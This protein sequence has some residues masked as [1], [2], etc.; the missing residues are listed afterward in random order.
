MGEA[1]GLDPDQDEEGR[2][3][4]QRPSIATLAGLV[5]AGA[6]AAPGLA[7]AQQLE[8]PRPSP[9]ARVMRQIGLTEITVDYSSPAVRKRRIWGALV[10]YDKPWRTGANAS[11]RVTFTKDVSVGGKTVPAG[12]YALLTIPG[13]KTWTVMLNRNTELAGNMDRYRPEEDVVRVTAVPR[14]IP[15]QE[16]L[17]FA[18]SGVTEDACVLDMDWEKLRISLPIKTFTAQ[19]ARQNIDRTLGGLWR[20]YANAA[21]Y[22]KD[23]KDYDAALKYIDQSLA[24]KEDWFNLWTKAEILAA[25]GER[26]QALALAQKAD[27]LGSKNPQG[28]I[29]AADVK[30]AL[31]EWKR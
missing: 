16:W 10:P 30:K 21:R 24:M 17:S 28:F 4:M 15:H 3:L 18:F 29:Y 11:T 22:M 8:L 1:A 7:G 20:V 26:K 5:L 9:G 14:A 23:Q 12:S 13:P 27:E 19:Q 25:R 2:Q 6:L 31:S